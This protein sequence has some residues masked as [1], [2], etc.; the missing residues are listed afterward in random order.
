MKD[1]RNITVLILSVILVT[2]CDKNDT[3]DDAIIV[4]NMA[5]HVYWELGSSTVNAGSDVPF[6]VQYYTTGNEQID[7]LEVWYNIVEEE[8][9]TVSCPWT[10][11]FTYSVSSTKSLEKRISQK[12]LA[13]PHNSSYWSDSL[14][15]YS[16][17]NVFPSSNTLSATNWIKPSTYENDKMVK[18]FG[19]KYIETFKDSLYKLMKATDFQKMYLGLNLVDNFKIYLDSTKNENSGVWDYH[20]PKDAQGNAPIPQAVADI[21]KTIPFA[22]LIYNSSTAVYEV[23]YSRSY[24]L[25]AN[26]KA[27]DK[28][29]VIG[30]A[31]S[32]EISLN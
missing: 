27:F 11:S 3:L 10:Q 16:F 1:I 14:H 7:R 31:L 24:K 12:I 29:G 17:S 22:D 28:N 2:S 18:Y 8:A 23:E 13:F 32:K 26:I 4:G 21:Y 9:K 5:P 30:L 19:T 6:I 25:N 20:F 15:A